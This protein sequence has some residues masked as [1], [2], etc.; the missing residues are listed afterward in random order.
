MY[1]LNNAATTWPKPKSV[2]DAMSDFML[3]CGANSSRGTSSE[4][5]MTSMNL[6][7]DCRIKLAELFGGNDNHNPLLV[8][9]TS[10]ITE[11]LNFVL[12]GFLKPGMK[13]LT[14]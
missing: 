1:Y 14:T 11:A 10:N 9:F 7:L 4:R 12:R 3:N 8:T 2:I 13:V 5:D 6:I